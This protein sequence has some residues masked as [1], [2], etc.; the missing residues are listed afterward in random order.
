MREELGKDLALCHAQPVL[1]NVIIVFQSY[2][3]PAFL[4]EVSLEFDDVLMNFVLS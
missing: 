2:C 4:Q 3:D 1:T